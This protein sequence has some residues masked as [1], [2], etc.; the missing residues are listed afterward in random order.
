MWLEVIISMLGLSSNQ[1]GAADRYLVIHAIFNPF[2][3]LEWLKNITD[4]IRPAGC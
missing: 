4:Y 1:V 2:D 3:T